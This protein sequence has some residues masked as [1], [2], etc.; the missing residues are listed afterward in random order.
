M[1][2]SP[3]SGGVR[4]DEH[5]RGQ[6]ARRG[7]KQRKTGVGLSVNPRIQ[8]VQSDVLKTTVLSCLGFG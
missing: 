3:A 6:D 4:T 5:G 1:K 8:M 2:Q 7:D